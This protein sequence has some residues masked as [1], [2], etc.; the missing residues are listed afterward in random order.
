MIIALLPCCPSRRPI[1]AAQTGSRQEGPGCCRGSR[2]CLSVSCR[3]KRGMGCHARLAGMCFINHWIPAFAGMTV[4]PFVRHSARARNRAV[5]RATDPF[6]LH[7]CRRTSMQA[8]A[9]L[10]FR[11][12]QEGPGC[13]RGSRFCL[14]V[15]CRPKRG[16]GCH[17]RLAGMCFINHWIPAFAGMTVK[18]FVRHSSRVKNRTVG[19]A[20][21]PFRLH[22]CRRT[23]L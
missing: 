11:R 1:I 3:P 9:L 18:P 13:C 7:P 6:R 2:F 14:S 10:S 4:K 20:T 17:A 15:S 19:R 22:P 5:G 21:D 16:M 23:S 8:P 12:Q